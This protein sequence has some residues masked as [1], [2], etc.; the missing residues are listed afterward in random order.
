M[1]LIE[2]ISARMVLINHA[3]ERLPIQLGY[4]IAMYIR[5]SENDAKFYQ[6]KLDEI[7]EEFAAKDPEGKFLHTKDNNIVIQNGKVDECKQRVKELE[8]TEVNPIALEKFEIG[9]LA[10]IQFTADELL[11]LYVYIDK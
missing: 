9:E 1:K 7:L 8:M 3:N 10:P 4:K 6:Q 11:K 5:A 2:Q